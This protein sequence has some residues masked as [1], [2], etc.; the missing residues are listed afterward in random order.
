MTNKLVVIIKVLKVTK[1]RKI[2]L[3]EMKFLVP[4]YSCL[5]NP[6]LVGYCHQIPFLSVLCPVEF[7]EPPPPEQ[8]SWVRH[9]YRGAKYLVTRSLGWLNFVWWC[10]VFVGQ[11]FGNCFTSPFWGLEIWCYSQMFVKF[12][13]SCLNDQSFSTLKF[14]WS[15]VSN[16]HCSCYYDYQVYELKM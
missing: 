16:L 1:I 2:L 12:V 11:Q 10:A 7:V 14:T 3:Y 4:N 5:Q 9:C 13:H 8:N 6:W 15:S